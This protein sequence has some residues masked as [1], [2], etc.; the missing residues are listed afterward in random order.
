MWKPEHRQAAER[1]TH[2]GVEQRERQTL[3][4][5]DARVADAEVALDRAHQQAQDGA[6]HERQHVERGQND[7]YVPGVAQAGAR[8]VCLRAGR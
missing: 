5:A 8:P 2:D 7:D 6:I 4:Q 1:Q 3:Q